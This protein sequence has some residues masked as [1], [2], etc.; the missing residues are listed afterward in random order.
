MKQMIKSME[1]KYLVPS[2]NLVEE[3][4]AE[5]DSTEEAKVVRQLVEE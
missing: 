1:K 2:L 5:A 3:V 4:F